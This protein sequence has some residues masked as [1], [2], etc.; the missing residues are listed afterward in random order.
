[1]RGGRD[2]PG[3]G[4]RASPGEGR[5]RERDRRQRRVLILRGAV[6]SASRLPILAFGPVCTSGMADVAFVLLTLAVFGV[7]ALVVKGVEKL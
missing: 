3:P 5:Q 6:S 4:R 1:V 2:S 7:L